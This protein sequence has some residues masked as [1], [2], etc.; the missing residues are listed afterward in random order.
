MIAHRLSTVKQASR[1]VVLD[2]GRI[3]EMGNHAELLE[4]RGA[5]YKLYTMQF[6]GQEAHAAD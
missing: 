4:R 1:V 2:Q 3:V 6:R 5:Y